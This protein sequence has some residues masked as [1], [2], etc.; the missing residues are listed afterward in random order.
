MAKKQPSIEDNLKRLEEIASI[1]DRGD[2]PIEEQLALFTE[3]MALAKQ[4]R[5]YLEEAELRIRQLGGI[6]EE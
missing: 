1:L 6:E 2:V 3:G 5:T 4:A